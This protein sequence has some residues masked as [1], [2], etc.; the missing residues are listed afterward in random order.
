MSDFSFGLNIGISGFS[1]ALLVLLFLTTLRQGEE[2]IDNSRG[3]RAFL[4]FLLLNLVEIAADLL[5]RLDGRPGLFPL[6]QAGNLALFLLNP[7]LTFCWYFYICG[8]IGADGQER[9]RGAFFHGI[10]FLANAVAAAAT[11][12]TGWLYYFD[13]ACVYHRGPLFWLTS[14]IMLLMIAYT[15]VTLLSR[16]S[17]LDRGHFLALCLFPVIPLLLT[18]LQI[19]CYG[20]AFALSGTAFSLLIVFLYVQSR[21][22]DIDYLTGLYNRRKLDICL[23]QKLAAAR[24]GRPFAAILL[25]IDQFKTINDT[26]GHGVGDRALRDAAGV[27]RAC[28]RTDTFIARY[29]GDEFCIVLDLASPE[30]LQQIMARI[31]GAAEDFNRSGERTYLI[32]FS[33][34]GDVCRP[35]QFATTEDFQRHIDELMY[36]DK[37]S[38]A[39]ASDRRPAVSGELQRRSSDRTTA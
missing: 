24:D 31:R 29:G 7:A 19:L 10:L 27:L 6:C 26:L 2:Q 35:G 28:M 11:P 3:R 21:S 16:R 25:D 36:E 37:R 33:M 39:A 12:F 9:R 5:S 22:L 38:H 1:L 14:C 32:S 13:A 4:L 17:A 18:G 34:G 30:P 23:Q 15:Q 20:V 8:Q